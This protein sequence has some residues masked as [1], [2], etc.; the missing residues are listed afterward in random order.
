M[1]LT[2]ATAFSS[3]TNS[4]LLAFFLVAVGRPA[5]QPLATLHLH[6]LD[7]E[8][9]FAGVLSVEFVGLVAD[10][11][12]VVAALHPGVH[13]VVDRDEAEPLLGKVNF[14]VL[15]HLEI[16][17]SQTA[18]ILDDQCL[19]LAVLDRLSTAEIVTQDKE[20]WTVEA[21]VFRKENEMWLRSQGNYIIQQEV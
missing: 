1:R 19:H 11:V 12:E 6:P 14:R 2:I 8:H 13:A 3:G 21:E 4:L 17:A 7:G 9:L 10:G 16:L 18:G 5:S 20:G 15:A